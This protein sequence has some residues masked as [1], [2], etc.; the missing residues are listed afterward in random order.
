M[1]GLGMLATALAGGAQVVGK[2]ASDDIE[3]GRKTD[4]MR[5]QAAI[6]EQM[7]MRL[8]EHQERIRQGG[9]L[10]DVTGS[11]GDAKLAYKGK[12]LDQTRAANV[13][14]AR[15]MI[16]VTQEA[17]KAGAATARQTTKDAAADT[18]YLASLKTVALANPEVA[19]HIAQMKAAANASNAAAGNSA[20]HAGLLSAQTVGVKL[21]NEDQKRLGDIYSGMDTALTDPKLGDDER[22]KKLNELEKRAALIQGRSGK[23]AGTRDPELNTTTTETTK[24]LPDGTQVKTTAKEVRKPGGQADDK[25]PYPD[26]TELRGKDGKTYVVRDGQPVLKGAPAKSEAR[27]SVPAAP[28]DDMAGIAF[29][30]DGYTVNGQTYSTPAEARAAR[31]K[32]KLA[33]NPMSKTLS[34]YGDD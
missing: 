16:P 8:S 23:N 17:T 13:A 21:G 12:E 22:A 30:G 20:A 4:L 28:V 2:Q 10:A 11:L 26:G 19:A 14:Q 24:M 3:A 29:S 33:A 1:S 18:G 5:E 27:P 15:D 9:A 32:A 6:E 31:D 25:A 7:R 34:R